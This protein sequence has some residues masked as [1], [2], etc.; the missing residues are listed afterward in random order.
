MLTFYFNVD[1]TI[2][3]KDGYLFIT[4]DDASFVNIETQDNI[5]FIDDLASK[6]CFY[7][8]SE[9]KWYVYMPIDTDI[10]AGMHLLTILPY[11][12]GVEFDRVSGVLWPA[13]GTYDARVEFYDASDTQISTTSDTHNKNVV[14]PQKFK[15][16]GCYNSYLFQKD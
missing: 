11:R 3:K 10:V 7:K 16:L 6:D 5:C 2:P 14:P 1:T 13:M 8:N 15:N 4:D 9:N 12:Q